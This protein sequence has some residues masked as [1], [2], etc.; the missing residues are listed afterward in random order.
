MEF[1]QDDESRNSCTINHITE[2]NAAGELNYN[3][4][5]KEAIKGRPSE[6]LL[7]EWQFED[8]RNYFVNERAGQ[9]HPIKKGW[10]FGA[11][12]ITSWNPPTSDTVLVI[13]QKL[14][15]VAQ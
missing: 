14:N 4:G 9:Q 7:V 13:I 6:T 3:F 11:C 12:S 1:I 10:S 8:P 2:F 5:Q 15:T